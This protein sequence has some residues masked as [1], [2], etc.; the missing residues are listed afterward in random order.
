MLTWGIIFF[1]T[2]SWKRG[3]GGRS[4][5]RKRNGDTFDLISMCERDLKS[6]NKSVAGKIAAN[7]DRYQIKASRFLPHPVEQEPVESPPA[8]PPGRWRI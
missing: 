7:L 1:S 3:G 8:V 5:A 2:E 6:V 4:T